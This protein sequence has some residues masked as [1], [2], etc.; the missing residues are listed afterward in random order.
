MKM[1]ILANSQHTNVLTAFN[2]VQEFSLTECPQTSWAKPLWYRDNCEGLGV[3]YQEL[4]I[5]G[6]QDG[7]GKGSWLESK[8]DEF[9][10]WLTSSPIS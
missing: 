1:H 10:R 4:G 6:R 2:V 3:A 9:P 5:L 7:Q 8:G